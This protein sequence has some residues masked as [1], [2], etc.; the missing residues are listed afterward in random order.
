M[1]TTGILEATCNL[2]AMNNGFIP[3]T[4][5]FSEARPGCTLDYVP[6]VPR[7]KEYE[8]FMSANYAFGG[9]NAAVVISKWD[10]PIKARGDQTGTG[11]YNRCRSGQ[12]L[13]SKQVSI[14]RL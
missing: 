11:I 1:G 9:N 5:N 10:T 3:P 2:L 7:E 8:A 14:S 13:V 4:L 6:N 12:F